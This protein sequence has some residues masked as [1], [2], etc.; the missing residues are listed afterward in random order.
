MKQEDD[1]MDRGR[2]IPFETA[3]N[4][5]EEY[6]DIHHVEKFTQCWGCLKFSHHDP[7]QMCFH[8][9]EGNRGC[10][11]VNRLFDEKFGAV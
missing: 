8:N 5:C 1:I 10:P 9:A 4:L 2:P 6:R 11:M 7:L 3:E